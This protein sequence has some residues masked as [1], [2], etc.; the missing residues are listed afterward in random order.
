MPPAVARCLACQAVVQQVGAFAR[1]REAKVRWLEAYG[2]NSRP[3]KVEC[4]MAWN[5]ER[6]V[7]AS[8]KSCPPMCAICCSSL[9][10]VVILYCDEAAVVAHKTACCFKDLGSL[11]CA[12]INLSKFADTGLY[13]S[14]M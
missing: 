12:H 9:S 8:Q 7:Q 14:A 10:D 1:E 2:Q 5:I 6:D 3:A 4:E 11:T 13:K